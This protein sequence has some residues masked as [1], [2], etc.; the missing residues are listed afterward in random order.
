M[1]SWAEIRSLH[2]SEDLPIKPIVRKLGVSQSAVR[3]ALA[4][5]APP[6]EVRPPEGSAVDAVEPQ[7]R[8]L[9]TEWPTMPATVIAERIGWARST[10]RS[11]LGRRD[12]RRCS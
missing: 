1:E 5:D 6:K 7:I 12:G 2:R 10:C 3:R 11:A 8:T 9:L 4:A